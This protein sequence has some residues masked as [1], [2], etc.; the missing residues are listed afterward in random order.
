MSRLPIGLL[1]ELLVFAAGKDAQEALLVD[2][3]FYTYNRY[4]WKENAKGGR[5]ERLTVKH[6]ALLALNGCIVTSIVTDG[7]CD[8]SDIEK[9]DLNGTRRL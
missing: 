7:D 9:A 4:E 6:H 3:S 5:W 2:S 1:D 8:D